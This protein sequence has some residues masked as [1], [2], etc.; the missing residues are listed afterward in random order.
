[1]ANRVVAL[2][3]PCFGN[4]LYAID[5]LLLAN[6]LVAGAV[7]SDLLLFVDNLLAGLHHRAALLRT[8]CVATAATAA[9]CATVASLGHAASQQQRNGKDRADSQQPSH[10]LPP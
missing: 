2:L 6:R 8:A 3:I 1:V 5:R 10:D 7:A 4:V 9:D